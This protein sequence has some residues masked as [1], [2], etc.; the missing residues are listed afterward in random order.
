MSEIQE[1]DVFIGRDGRVRV[2]IRGV[3]GPAC[4]E[5]TKE[6]TEL[7][8]GRVVDHQRTDEYDQSP[9]SQDQ[10]DRPRLG[11]DSGR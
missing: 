2:E 1:V 11:G 3:K 7:L 9:L 6:M 4:T 8:G 5:I 10:D